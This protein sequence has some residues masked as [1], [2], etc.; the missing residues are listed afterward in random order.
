MAHGL[1]T[2]IV[3]VAAALMAPVVH[4]Q[5]REE[6]RAL[7]ATQ[8][9][10]ELRKQHDQYI[11]D[12]LLE[13]AYGIAV[14]PEVKKLALGVGGRFG[15]GVIVVRDKDG[16]FSNPIFV[17]LAGGSFGWQI[18]AQETDVVLVFTTRRGIEGITGGKLTLGADASVA[19]GPLGRDASAATD[20]NFSAEIYSYSRS[21]GLFAGVALDGSV[22]TIDRRADRQFYGE[23][24][25]EASDIISGSVKKDSETVRRLLAAVAVGTRSNGA[26]SD[27]N[28]P[29]AATPTAGTAKVK[30][31]GAASAAGAA[32]AASAPAAAS[33]AKTYPMEDTKPGQEPPK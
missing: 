9:L 21:R 27:T 19:A 23:R 8:V 10:E 5:A 24:N 2:M 4:A 3:V 33:D 17:S 14:I 18:G 16:R 29:A 7:V 13:R 30:A 32:E 12:R 1:P 20:A 15:R 26:A 28:A 6:A 31:A 11:P 25:V 22:L